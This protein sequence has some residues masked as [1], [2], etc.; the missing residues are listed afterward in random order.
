MT[1]QQVVVLGSNCNGHAMEVGSAE[2]FLRT[3][4]HGYVGLP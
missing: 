3:A 2:P 1:C 4:R